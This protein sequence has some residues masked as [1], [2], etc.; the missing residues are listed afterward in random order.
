MATPKVSAI[1]AGTA[2]KKELIDLFKKKEW[3]SVPGRDSDLEAL[4]SK[5]NWNRSQITRHF[6]IWYDLGDDSNRNLDRSKESIIACYTMRCASAKEIFKRTWES[7]DIQALRNHSRVSL[8]PDL[9]TKAS[10]P[11]LWNKFLTDIFEAAA[12]NRLLNG[13]GIPQGNAKY[14]I[15]KENLVQ[16]LWKSFHDG[17]ASM[18][19]IRSFFYILAKEFISQVQKSF[20]EPDVEDVETEI[21]EQI[22]KTKKP[23]PKA[24]AET[25]YFISGYVLKAVA[26]EG[27]RRK[28]K[29]TLFMHFAER[30]GLTKQ[31]IAKARESGQLPMEKT[32]T[33]NKGGRRYPTHGFYEVMVKIEH[34]YCALLTDDNLVAFGTRAMTRI[35]ARIK[36]NE[37]VRSR[38]SA[39]IGR[40]AV[41]ADKVIDFVL[42]TYRRVRG[43][44]YASKLLARSGKSYATATRT[45]LQVKTESKK[46]TK[47]KGGKQSGSGTGTTMETTTMMTET[48]MEQTTR[49]MTT[50]KTTETETASTGTSMTASTAITVSTTDLDEDFLDECAL[51][52]DVFVQEEAATE[53]QLVRAA[54]ESDL[55]SSSSE[56]S[57]DNRNYYAE[58]DDESNDSMCE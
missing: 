40:K 25:L 11:T 1:R 52:L 46:N 39:A 29:G 9:E 47:H 6:R 37:T 23:L 38:L 56:D 17:T 22:L 21:I 15:V 35:D 14:C 34:I 58:G 3:D 57:F 19:R 42:Q 41:G 48:T 20:A 43:S 36:A 8:T 51:G 30:N 16:K 12:E 33:G 49:M 55:G 5:H 31:L 2:E 24:H 13:N 28:S 10:D 26:L 53:D 32:D 7:H 27:D 45:T 54:D 4:M 18:A 50:E 44:D